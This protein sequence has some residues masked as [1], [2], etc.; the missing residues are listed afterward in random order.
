MKHANCTNK[1]LGPYGSS[2]IR[3]GEASNGTLQAY[4]EK[5]NAVIEDRLRYRWCIELAEGFAYIHSKDVIHSDMRLDNVLVNAKLG[6][7]FCDFGGSKCDALGLDGKHFPDDPFF[8]P[9]LGFVST[10]ATDIFSL[11]S[12]LFVI[13]TGN[14]LFASGLKGEPFDDMQSYEVYVNERFKNGDFPDVTGLIGGDVIQRCWRHNEDS[15]LK[16]TAD[17]LS[18]LR[19]HFPGEYLHSNWSHNTSRFLGHAPTVSLTH[20]P[21][22]EMLG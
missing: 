3:L 9:R 7:W 16:T 4:L 20:E 5:H 13:L 15:G 2:S 11:G 22:V 18:A 1:Y 10:P 6:L 19:S 12:L 21:S 17:V 8:D 14:L